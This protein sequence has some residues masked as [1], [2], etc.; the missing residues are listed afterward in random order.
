[1][2]AAGRGM[3]CKFQHFAGHAQFGFGQ[4]VVVARFEHRHRIIGGLESVGIDILQVKSR[5]G[6]ARRLLAASTRERRVIAFA[7]RKLRRR[8]I[9][10]DG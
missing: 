9:V 8:A 7:C 1:M 2:H 10:A 3:P 4:R 6:T 5:G